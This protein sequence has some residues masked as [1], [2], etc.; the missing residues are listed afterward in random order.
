M[1]STFLQDNSDSLQ[2]S[3]STPQ[4]SLRTYSRWSPMEEGVTLAWND[5][6]VYAHVKDKSTKTYKRIITEGNGFSELL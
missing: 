4:R 1:H 2:H 3:G 6:S 5:L